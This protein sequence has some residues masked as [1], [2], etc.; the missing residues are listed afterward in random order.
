MRMYNRGICYELIGLDDLAIEDISPSIEIEPRAEYRFE[1]RGT[2]YFR[3]NLIDKALADYEEALVINPQYPSALYGRGII[4]MRKGDLPAAAPTS[5][6]RRA[7]G[8]PSPPKWPAP[9]SNNPQPDAPARAEEDLHESVAEDRMQRLTA[10]R[11]TALLVGTAACSQYTSA[12]KLDTNL[13]S[14]VRTRSGRGIEMR[15]VLALIPMLGSLILATVGCHGAVITAEPDLKVGGTIAGI[16][17]ATDGTMPLVT[18]KV[19]VINAA[20]GARFETT[21]GVNGGYTIKVPEEGRYRIE[22][23]LRDGEV[24]AKGPGETDINNGDLDPGRDFEITVRAGRKKGIAV[25]QDR[26]RPNTYG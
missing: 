7:T 12:T 22:V 19:T 5:Q 1:R 9:A 8:R 20:S 16:V 25:G 14:P 17:R 21:T 15:A 23:E 2:I 4:R 13:C 10:V 26:C 18:R 6:Q 11:F 3:N 24:V